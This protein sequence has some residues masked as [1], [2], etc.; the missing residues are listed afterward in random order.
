MS[1]IRCLAADDL[2]LIQPLF[3]SV[4]DSSISSALL[5]WKYANGRGSSWSL[6]QEGVLLMHCG[7]CLRHVLLH[8]EPVLAAQL[9]DLMAA[10]KSAGLSRQ[11]SPFALLMR[12]IL[13]QLPSPANPEG[14]AF[15]FPSARAMRLGEHAGVYCAVDQWMAL[16]FGPRQMR[17]GPRAREIVTW[18]SRETLAA[19]ALWTRMRADL[20][21]FVVGVRDMDYL[22]HRYLT[23]PDKRYRVL[24]VESHWRRQPMGLLVLGPGTGDN[25]LV[26]VICAWDDIAE[27]LLAAR[28]WLHESGGLRLTLNLTSHFANPLAALADGC[29]ETQF[30][31]MANPQT[32]ANTLDKLKQQWWLTGGDTDYR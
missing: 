18:G 24:L 20:A 2:T 12:H 23:H 5:Q 32:P 25:E 30:R 26:D 7:L 13:A 17:L 31:I 3:A 28:R 4:F 6:W 1:E 16:E 9:V 15:G 22:R 8:G 29:T 10:P 27:S 11:M 19:D 14:M 21:H